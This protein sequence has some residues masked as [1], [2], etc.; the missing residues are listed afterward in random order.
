MIALVFNVGFSMIKAMQQDDDSKLDQTCVLISKDELQFAPN[1][2]VNRKTIE[3]HTHS[4]L[5]FLVHAV[6]HGSDFIFL[7]YLCL[8]KKW[9]QPFSLI[10]KSARKKEYE[11]LALLH[12]KNEI[13]NDDCIESLC[14]EDIFEPEWELL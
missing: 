7:Y 11:E 12:G 14:R 5:H 2:T 13:E 10:K 9:L 8:K 1:A 6:K 4:P 3:V